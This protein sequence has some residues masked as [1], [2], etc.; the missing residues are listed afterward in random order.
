VHVDAGIAPETAARFVE[1]AMGAGKV[2]SRESLEGATR[3]LARKFRKA[4]GHQGLVV[5][6]GWQCG[7]GGVARL[8]PIATA[9]CVT[10][11]TCAA[12][13]LRYQNL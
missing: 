7:R 10:W 2:G 12:Q 3:R 13:A 5:I 4:Q 8:P 1:I 11:R 6:K 9:E